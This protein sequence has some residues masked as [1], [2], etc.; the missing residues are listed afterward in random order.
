M[1]V[2]SGVNLRADAWPFGVRR[3]LGVLYSVG[4]VRP[5]HVAYHVA[6]PRGLPR[7]LD[8]S[9]EPSPLGGRSCVRRPFDSLHV[10]TVLA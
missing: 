9:S 2:G 10:R 6:L 7:G 5:C 8:G 1:H 3:R 4:L